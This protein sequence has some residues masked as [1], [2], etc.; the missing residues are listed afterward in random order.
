MQSAVGALDHHA[1]LQVARRFR[2]ALDF[3]ENE[4][5]QNGW[6]ETAR[7]LC[8]ARDALA[9]DLGVGAFGENRGPNLQVTER[10]NG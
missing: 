2:M 4:A 1:G 10:E 8:A 3:L 7:T 6:S 5:S 9:D